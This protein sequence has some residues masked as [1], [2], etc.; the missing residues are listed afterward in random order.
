MIFCAAETVNLCKS[1]HFYVFTLLPGIV[2]EVFRHLQVLRSS[3]RGCSISAAAAASSLRTHRHRQSTGWERR[4]FRTLLVSYKWAW[5]RRWHLEKLEAFQYTNW[6]GRVGKDRESEREEDKRVAENR[7][8]SG[9]SLLPGK[10]P[11]FPLYECVILM[12]TYVSVCAR[13]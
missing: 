12:F 1:W 7:E 10:F 9:S 11:W 2:D 3:I 13:K 4:H 5:T 6:R 8:R